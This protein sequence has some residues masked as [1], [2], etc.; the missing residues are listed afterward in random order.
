MPG[1]WGSANRA[2]WT[3]GAKDN[4][5]PLEWPFSNSLH[6]GFRGGSF[7]YSVQGLDA[8]ASNVETARRHIQALGLLAWEPTRLTQK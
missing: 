6:S 3:P 1:R 7:G 2:N 5:R 8:D 4:N